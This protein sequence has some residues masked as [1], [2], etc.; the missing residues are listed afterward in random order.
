M[1]GGLEKSGG[2]RIRQLALIGAVVTFAIYSLFKVYF[3]YLRPQLDRGQIKQ[4]KRELFE[5]LTKEVYIGSLKIDGATATPEERARLEPSSDSGKGQR[6]VTVECFLQFEPAK[7]DVLIDPTKPLFPMKNY[8][9]KLVIWP[10]LVPGRDPPADNEILLKGA[11]PEISARKETHAPVQ[12]HLTSDNG[13]KLTTMFVD[14]RMKRISLPGPSCSGI[15]D[16]R[17]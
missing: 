2:E 5:A 14:P 9:F 6:S 11:F 1:E 13:I 4:D 16:R 12:F 8:M 3:F 17:F 10:E 15:S 7:S